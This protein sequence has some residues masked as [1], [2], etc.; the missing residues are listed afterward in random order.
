MFGVEDQLAVSV[1]FRSDDTHGP[2]TDID[3]LDCTDSDFDN[4]PTG[5]RVRWVQ[6]FQD[7][8]GLGTVFNG[9]IGA[10]LYFEKS[11][12]I[13]FTPGSWMSVA[14]AWTL[15]AMQDGMVLYRNLYLNDKSVKPVNFKTGASQV[16]PREWA[17]FYDMFYTNR[18]NF[19]AP[20][21]ANQWGRAEMAGVHYGVD[22]ADRNVGRPLGEEGFV[23]GQALIA[24]DVFRANLIRNGV[25]PALRK[26]HWNPSGDPF[27]QL[28]WGM[29]AEGTARGEWAALRASPGQVA[30]T[31][32]YTRF[33]LS[34]YAMKCN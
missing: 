24:T 31:Q 34:R 13:N 28:L 29:M 5:Q 14:D 20:N 17:K 32:W 10:I 3:K 27:Q 7:A 2:F 6:Q 1:H 26:S 33:C 22:I 16:V 4:M 18:G 11:E 19:Y 21:V 15:A 12:V 9:V 8:Y 23:I 25:P 30:T